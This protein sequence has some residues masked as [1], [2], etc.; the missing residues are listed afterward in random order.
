M[1]PGNPGREFMVTRFS[2]RTLLVVVSL[3]SLVVALAAAV[4]AQRRSEYRLSTK[5]TGTDVL[6][7][8]C[9]RFYRPW[10]HYIE[11][12]T[13]YPPC[14]ISVTISGDAENSNV[15]LESV[16]DLESNNLSV[17]LND[18]RGAPYIEL[19]WN[20]VTSLYIRRSS[21]LFV[22]SVL[23]AVP[24]LESL[25]LYDCNAVTDKHLKNLR[26]CP[27]LA[28][29]DLDGTAVDGRFFSS[30][31]AMHSPLES[32]SIR[33]SNCCNQESLLAF[34]HSDSLQNIYL[35]GSGSLD[36]DCLSSLK[37]LNKLVLDG[38]AVDEESVKNLRTRFPDAT[39]EVVP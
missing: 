10:D 8:D 7:T 17:E 2:I 13:G 25:T 38:F 9:L 39:I 4:I 6:F 36:V 31:V 26:L 3:I 5:A 19:D 23:S 35:S 16:R 34:S 29:L 18:H 37:S 24:R 27:R 30:G 33:Y 32:L 22:E 14:C 21:G 12:L 15:Q 1:D 11:R 20:N 28:E